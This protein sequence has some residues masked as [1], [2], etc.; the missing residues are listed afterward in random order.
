[1]KKITY[2]ITI[3]IFSSVSAQMNE[4]VLADTISF[5]TSE[6]KAF[7]SLNYSQNAYRLNFE[8]CNLEVETKFN[9]VEDEWFIHDIWLSEIDEEK[10][11]LE[12]D[13]GGWKMTLVSPNKRIEFD[14][15]NGSGWVSEIHIYNKDQAPLLAVGRALY[16]AIKSCKGLD[17]FKK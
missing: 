12:F 13:E 7:E 2:I 4:K 8:D 9:G 14:S 16:Y 1:M 17:R 15:H 3:L 11:S 6:I 5:I 10:M